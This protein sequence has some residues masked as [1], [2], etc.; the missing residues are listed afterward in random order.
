MNAGREAEPRPQRL[1]TAR[2][3]ASSASPQARTQR[4]PDTPA[5]CARATTSAR[6]SAIAAIGQV[7]MAVDHLTRLPGGGGLSN[8]RS[9]GNPPSGLAAST[10]PFDSIAHQFR[11]LEVGHDDDGPADQRLRLVG[12]GDAGHQ[13]ARFAA[14]I[15]LHLDQLP[16]ALQLLGGQDLRHAQDRSSRSRRSGS[17]RPPAP[18]PAQRAGRQC[19]RVAGRAG[20]AGG[21]PTG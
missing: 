3:P 11:R 21:W 12:L 10:M 4:P 15:H 17:S 8:P 16:R 18:P 19:S 9:T 2:R 14:G 20:C 13:R 7:A 5:S 6:S 1:D